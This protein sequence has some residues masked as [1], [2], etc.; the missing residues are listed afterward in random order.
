LENKD[1][2]KHPIQHLDLYSVDGPDQLLRGF[3][4]TSSESRNPAKSR[5][6]SQ[7]ML[8]DETANVFL[9]VAG[10]FVPGGMPKN[11]I[12]RAA[13]EEGVPVYVNQDVDSYEIAQ[14]K[15]KT[16]TA[17]KISVGGGVPKNHIQQPELLLDTMSYKNTDG[18][19]YAIQTTINDPKWGGLI[20]C[21]LKKAQSW[22]ELAK[23]A[24]I[25][26]VYRQ[27][28]RIAAHCGRVFTIQ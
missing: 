28:H 1:L 15:L 14:I 23:D 3:E 22:G 9:G 17:G 21:T 18:R 6:V 19:K 16:R 5:T 2:L 25:A 7:G 24:Q 20:G 4:K 8:K 13:Y 10:A 26:A 27:R 11:S 12:L